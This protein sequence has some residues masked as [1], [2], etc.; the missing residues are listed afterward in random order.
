MEYIRIVDGQKIRFTNP[1]V[2]GDSVVYNPTP[3][4]L[5]ANGWVLEEEEDCIEEDLGQTT[6]YLP[7]YEEKVNMLIREKYSIEDELA[8]IR[9]RDTDPEGYNK[10]FEYCEECKRLA[11]EDDN[12]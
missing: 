11:K 6:S 1:L 8:R 9:Q 7:T 10:Y 4:M 5:Q 12:N 2:I 3:D